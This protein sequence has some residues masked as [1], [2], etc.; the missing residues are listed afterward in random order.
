M[1]HVVRKIPVRCPHCGHEQPE[2]AHVIS[3]YCRNCGDHFRAG[4]PAPSH[5]KPG[6]RRPVR[7]ERKSRPAPSRRVLC[8]DCGETHEVAPSALSTICPGCTAAIDFRDA[9][10]SSNSSTHVNTRGRLHVEAGGFL[11]SENLVCGEA[12]VEGRL[13]G[14]LFC[15]GRLSLA[16]RGRLSCWIEAKSICVEKGAMVEIPYPVETGELIVRGCLTAIV[17]CHGKVHVLR[18]GSIEGKVRA[19]ALLVERGGLFVAESVFS[20]RERPLRH[21]ES[22][23][24]SLPE[25]V[26]QSFT[27]A[28]AAA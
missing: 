25:I 7:Q 26:R 12:L 9:V 1:G 5:E 3:T 6:P 18:G 2:P 10:F 27:Q 11:A 21:H 16:C 24:E 17:H 8:H 14:H 22:T 20:H 19:K 4:A 23:P 28:I 15:E 13:S